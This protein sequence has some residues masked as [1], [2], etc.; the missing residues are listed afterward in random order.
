MSEPDDAPAVSANGSALGEPGG[1]AGV[2]GGAAGAALE[3][4]GEHA[5][6]LADRAAGAG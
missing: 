4:D 2:E 5:A 1:D 3:G 6:I